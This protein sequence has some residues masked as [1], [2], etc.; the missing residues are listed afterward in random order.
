[1]FD[2][3]WL[4]VAGVSIAVIG[5]SGARPAIF[6]IPPRFLSGA[7]AAGG[8]ALIN[9]FG[10][11]GGFLGPYAIG[12]LRQTT[13]GFT[14]ALYFLAASMALSAVLAMGVRFLKAKT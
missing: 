10:N 3:L 4:A 12:W 5:M 11:L 13:G 14:A 7:A 6:C 2:S 8:I 1:M 9:S